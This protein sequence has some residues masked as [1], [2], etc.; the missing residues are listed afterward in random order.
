MSES[1]R[2]VLF[3]PPGAGKGTQSQLLI[4]RFS[5]THVSS[6]DLFRY[7]LQQGTPLGLQA[8]SYMDQGELVPDYVTV[9]IVLEKIMSIDNA[10][11][12][13]LDGFPRN[14]RQAVEL[15]S[16]LKIR[17]RG[18]DKVVHIDV[19]EPELERRLGGRFL[20]RECQAPYNPEDHS[21]PPECGRC[22]GQLY[23][24]DDDRPDAVKHR[25][26]VYREA[27]LPLLSF[28]QE[29]DLLVKVGGDATVEEV[30]LRILECLEN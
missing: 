30:N 27:T 22:G 15:E 16:A 29:R 7:N 18:L 3:G 6:G 12:F 4:D 2:L 21:G 9:D 8:K 24:R 11:G 5:L 19:S 26:E 10:D 13:I 14:I 20:C 17:S 1:L 28:Y 25:I 23:Q